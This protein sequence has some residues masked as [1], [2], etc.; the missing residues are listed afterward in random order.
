MENNTFFYNHFFRFRGTF[1]IFPAC[2][3]EDSFSNGCH[4]FRMLTFVTIRVLQPPGP[5]A[6]EPDFLLPDRVFHPC[7][8]LGGTDEDI[9]IPKMHKYHLGISL[10]HMLVFATFC[11]F[12]HSLFLLNQEQNFQAS[13]VLKIF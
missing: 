3:P 10:R 9:V 7:Q 12:F 5:A 4:R 2:A 13:S 8:N 11:L 6:G 1:P